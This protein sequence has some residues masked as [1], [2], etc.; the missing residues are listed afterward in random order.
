MFSLGFNGVFLGGPQVEAKLSKEVFGF[1]EITISFYSNRV[2]FHPVILFHLFIWMSKCLYECVMTFSF[3]MN[4]A[5]IYFAAVVIIIGSE[6]AH[7]VGY[8]WINTPNKEQN[9]KEIMCNANNS[10]AHLNMQTHTHLNDRWDCAVLWEM[11]HCN[12]N[13]SL[14]LCVCALLQVLLFF[15]LLP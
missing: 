2:S 12:I 15:W 5:A 11:S 8:L 6:H 3:Q 1:S 10:I 7:C 9:S 13:V 14:S 4:A